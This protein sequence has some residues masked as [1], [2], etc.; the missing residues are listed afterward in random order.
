MKNEDICNINRNYAY[1]KHLEE[2]LDK[3]REKVKRL[4][5]NCEKLKNGIL[6]TKNIIQ[7]E[8]IKYVILNKSNPDYSFENFLDDLL[9]NCINID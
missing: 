7:N 9:E 6:L 1:E 8:T 3:E 4:K 5:S 2:M